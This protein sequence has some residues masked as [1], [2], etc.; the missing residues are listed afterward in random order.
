MKLYILIVKVLYM[1]TAV[2]DF[3]ESQTAIMKLN[4]FTVYNCLII[5]FYKIWKSVINIVEVKNIHLLERVQP[6]D[7]GNLVFRQRHSQ[8]IVLDFGQTDRSLFPFFSLTS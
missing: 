2:L 4:T 3:F 6:L 8:C 7:Q 1:A 5:W